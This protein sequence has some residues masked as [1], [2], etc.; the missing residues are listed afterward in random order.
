LLKSTNEIFE[1]LRR[2]KLRLNHDFDEDLDVFVT[3][4]EH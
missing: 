2:R 3:D 1:F 4:K